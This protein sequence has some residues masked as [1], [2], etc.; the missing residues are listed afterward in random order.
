VNLLKKKSKKKIVALLI[1]LALVIG[2]LPTVQSDTIGKKPPPDYGVY[3]A[4]EEV[5][6]EKNSRINSAE[7]LNETKDRFDNI[8][9][10]S[11]DKVDLKSR[12]IVVTPDIPVP[13]MLPIYDAL[14]EWNLKH[15]NEIIDWLLPPPIGKGTP[16]QYYI[17]SKY[18]TNSTSIENW[19]NASLRRTIIYPEPNLSKWW[20]VDVDNDTVDDIEVYFNPEFYGLTVDELIDRL[21]PPQDPFEIGVRVNYNIRKI[22]DAPF[23]IP[24]F[25]NLE[26]YIAKSMSYSDMNFLLF[27]GLN[28]T[29]VVGNLNCLVSVEKVR[30]GDV[31]FTLIPGFPPSVEIDTADIL[32]MA[33]PYTIEWDSNNEQLS[34]LGLDVA[35]ARIEF[36]DD[37]EY[38]YINRSWVDVDF[39][40]KYTPGTVPTTARLYVEADDD[41]SSFDKIEWDALDNI[42]CDSKVRFFDSQV[43]VTYAEIEIEDLPNDIDISMIVEEENGEDISTIEYDASS[44]ISKL[45]AHHYEFFDTSYEDITPMRIQNGDVEYIHLFLNVERIPRYLYLKGVFYL[46]DVDDMPSID[47]GF[48]MISQLIDSIVYRVI[49]RFSRI[50]L[51]AIA[52]EG[53]IA[54][55]DTK[56]QIPIGEIEF[57]FTSGDYATI[58]D[59]NE[60]Y[61][62]FYNI[63]RPSQY[64]I[65]QISLAGRISE[66]DYI[67]ASFEDYA[68]AEV[69]MMDGASFRGIYADDINNL[70]AE[71]T[72]SNIPGSIF[73]YK[74]PTL[75]YYLGSASV[76][77]LRYI[78]EYQNT[79]MDIGLTDT[80]SMISLQY[81][82]NR[83][84]I[85][86]G[87]GEDS[88]GEIEFLVTTG[89]VLRMEG[90]HLLLRHETNY[91]LI[92]G[93]IKDISSMDY[94]SGDD[95][96]LDIN[97]SQENM[98]NISLFDNRS[99]KI[100]ADLIIDPIPKSLSINFS[101][102]F[103]T[104]G[105]NFQLP[106][107]KSGG[108]LGIVNIIFGVAGLGNE[109]LT[110]ID[111]TTQNALNNIG[112][113]IE[114]LSFSYSTISSTTLIG[115]ILRGDEFTLDD[116]DWMHGISAI[117]Q[118]DSNSTSMAAKLYMSGLPT[119]ASIATQVK[120][121][122]IFLDFH[123]TD[124]NP[125]HD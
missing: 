76:S 97:F 102:L 37:D 33:G 58:S 38:E 101:G 91:E 19:T 62:A 95:G 9:V 31:N 81:T 12:R 106:H 117:Q 64:P 51:L 107:L 6:D 21:I 14:E 49:S 4:M 116:V 105:T 118:K 93:R 110:V 16:M 1:I 29:N 3:E 48:E 79:Y 11:D 32:Q 121:D 57:I 22:N 100:S 17:Y 90:N 54:V 53:S 78:S 59:P 82:E 70:N 115:K 28:I 45:T 42:I 103:S 46:E 41:L 114:E 109:I 30:I 83:T 125:K 69:R 5:Q 112:S 66:V 108:V 10:V 55:V 36:I 7:I 24:E 61:F 65:A 35:T 71:I 52:E 98:I 20:G 88:I 39:I 89:P 47:P 80:A 68:L 123:L 124:Y 72:I 99:E 40:R 96:K 23:S 74:T 120:G 85:M 92:S 34:S 75:I 84:K 60:N 113:I 15:N 25:V 43:N 50:K 119:A 104:A 8:D 26:V 2:M 87:A 86:T 44:T 77:E 73:V 111:D 122:N 94:I 67:D 18:N 56:S 27:V 63:T 13:D